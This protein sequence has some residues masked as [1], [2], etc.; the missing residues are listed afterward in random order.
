[1]STRIVSTRIVSAR[2]A[3]SCGE[4][5][6]KP[7]QRIGRCQQHVRFENRRHRMCASAQC[8]REIATHHALA[9]DGVQPKR[10]AQITIAHFAKRVKPRI[11][12][13]AIARA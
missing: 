2:I 11:V 9:F 6:R 1:M 13:L 12:R 7:A 4:Y 10:P 8:G 5:I 3:N